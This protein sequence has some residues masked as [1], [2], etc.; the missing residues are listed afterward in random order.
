MPS[1]NHKTF[2]LKILKVENFMHREP[3]EQKT[4]ILSDG[5]FVTLCRVSPVLTV[6]TRHASKQVHRAVNVKIP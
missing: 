5:N 3:T 1:F 6:I 2:K 4:H